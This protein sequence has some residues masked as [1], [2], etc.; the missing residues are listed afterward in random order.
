MV[1]WGAFGALS[2]P[3]DTASQVLAAVSEVQEFLKMHDEK[4]QSL[5]GRSIMIR[6]G[7]SYGASLVGTV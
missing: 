7:I 5:L 4:I 2:D 1:L 6:F 3:P